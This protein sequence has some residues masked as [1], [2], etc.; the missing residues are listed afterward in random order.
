MLEDVALCTDEIVICI[1][2]FDP[3]VKNL[4]IGSKHEWL[5]L[6]SKIEIC[7]IKKNYTSIYTWAYIDGFSS[8]NRVDVSLVVVRRWVIPK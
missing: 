7:E 8:V 2:Y 4:T 5:R 6:D 1:G 3:F